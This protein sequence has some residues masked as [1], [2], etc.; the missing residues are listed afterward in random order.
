MLGN[1]NTEIAV[2]YAISSEFSWRVRQ[3]WSGGDYIRNLWMRSDEVNPTFIRT[4]RNFI[5]GIDSVLAAVLSC[6]AT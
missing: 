3:V 4:L 6:T 2:M 1:E 5:C